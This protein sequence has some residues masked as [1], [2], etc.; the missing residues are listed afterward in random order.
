MVGEAVAKG[1]RIASDVLDQTIEYLAHW[2]GNIID[3]LEPDIIV[4]GGGVGK[5]LKQ[6]LEKISERLRG[7]C[8]NQR[9]CEIPIVPARFGENAGIAGAAALCREI[10]AKR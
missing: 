1:D 8:E 5:M 2:L 7:C 3:L 10:I 9:A 6:F 4:F